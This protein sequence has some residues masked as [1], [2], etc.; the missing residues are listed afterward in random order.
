MILKFAL[1]NIVRLPWRT[2]LYFSIIFF[3]VLAIVASLCVYGACANAKAALNENYIFVASMLPKAENSLRLSDVGTGLGNTSALSYNV[4]MSENKG[5]IVGGDYLFQMPTLEGAETADPVYIPEN[6][7]SLVAVENLYLVDSFFSGE[8]SVKEGTGLTWRGYEGH[9]AELVV[10]WWFAEQYDISVGDT[11]T[12]RYYRDDYSTVYGMYTFMQGVVVG[13]Y[14]TSDLTPNYQ[15]YPVYMP[16]AVAEMDY[17]TVTSTTT[18]TTDIYVDR[19]DFV[20]PS[21]DSFAEFVE[22]A[23]LNGLDMQRVQIVFNN[24]IYDTL[25]GDLDNIHT[26]AMAV[27]LVVSLVGLCVFIFFTAYLCHSRKREG[28]LL[29]ALGMQKT[30]IAGMIALELVLIAIVA[31]GLAI[32]MGY[33]AADGV[34]AYVNETVLG[35]AEE[36]AAIQ[37][38]GE[39]DGNHALERKITMAVSVSD[40]SVS[41]PD[42][43]INYIQKVK[44]GD[45]GISTAEFYRV[46]SNVKDLQI[47]GARIPATVVGVSNFDE[48]DLSLPYEEIENLSNYNEAV[49]YAYVSQ[50]FDMS[51]LESNFLFI[52]PCLED[53]YINLTVFGMEQAFISRTCYVVVVGTYGENVYCGDGDILISLY[54]FHRLYGTLGITDDDFRFERIHTVIKKEEE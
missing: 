39:S 38:V 43:E 35:S 28:E 14:E 11:I 1:R 13:I 24:R 16:M 10:P 47:E 18:P 48:F 4:S 30:K 21:R 26:I 34:C 42:V 53:D 9:L 31:I 7:V 49:V 2:I 54:D 23:R 6:A 5:V 20:L 19:V 8:C 44:K 3:T 52:T 41:S 22:D 29:I 51:T 50:D 40:V 33:A 37:N 15:D 17:A 12:K 46:G 36:S 32:P 25:I 45:L 27:L